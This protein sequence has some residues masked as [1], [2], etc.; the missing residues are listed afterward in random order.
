MNTSSCIVVPNENLPFWNPYSVEVLTSGGSL[1]WKGYFPIN[2][3]EIEFWRQTA[4]RKS[5]NFSFN[6]ERDDGSIQSRNPY[7]IIEHWTYRRFWFFRKTTVCIFV[8]FL[9]PVSDRDGG[10]NTDGSWMAETLRCS[11]EKKSNEPV[12]LCLKRMSKEKRFPLIKIESQKNNEQRPI[13][14]YGTRN[15]RRNHGRSP[16]GTGRTDGKVTHG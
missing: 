10:W 9:R 12:H 7:V 11:F 15:N 4:F 8:N 1:V 5:E 2:E 16:H 3:F 13:K 14:N 6:Y